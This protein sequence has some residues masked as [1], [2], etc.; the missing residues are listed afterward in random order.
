MLEKVHC[1]RWEHVQKDSLPCF[2]SILFPSRIQSTE[3]VCCPRFAPETVNSSHGTEKWPAVWS[4]WSIRSTR[5]SIRFPRSWGVMELKGFPLK[6][7]LASSACFSQRLLIRL[8]EMLALATREQSPPVQSFSRIT[9]TESCNVAPRAPPMWMLWPQTGVDRPLLAIAV[10]ISCSTRWSP[11]GLNSTRYNTSKLPLL[12]KTKC[13]NFT[14]LNT[15]NHLFWLSAH[16]NHALLTSTFLESIVKSNSAWVLLLLLPFTQVPGSASVKL[17]VGYLC[18]NIWRAHS[19][20]NVPRRAGSNSARGCP[21]YA[22]AVGPTSFHKSWNWKALNV[23]NPRVNN[24]CG[25]LCPPGK[26]I[27]FSLAHLKLPLKRAYLCGCF[28]I[29]I[30]LKRVWNKIGSSLQK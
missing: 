12:G 9:S 29:S 5:F 19:W 15:K 24:P 26:G 16:C 23:T 3:A 2:T 30:Q 10:L 27:R 4:I 1:Q 25:I 11:F 6:N 17:E 22:R 20:N 7:L 14:F 13:G 18:C 8:S 28:Q 21:S